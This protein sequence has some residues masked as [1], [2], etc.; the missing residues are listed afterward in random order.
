MAEYSV[1]IGGRA[2]E[3]LNKAGMVLCSL[4]HSQ[5]YHVYLYYDYPSLIRGGHNFSI[6][7]AAE[8]PIFAHRD[9]VDFLLAMNQETVDRHRTRLS[10]N[11]ILLYDDY[12]V[13]TQGGVGLPLERILKETGAPE[14]ARNTGIIAGFSCAAGIPWETLEGVL[15]R[16]IPRGIES[17]LAVARAVYGVGSTLRQIPALP[18]MGRFPILTGN[19]ATGIGL[20]AG[21]L[22]SFIAYP[23]TP[24]SNLLHF[25]AQHADRYGLKVVHPE[26]EIGVMLMA[27]GAAYGGE[28]VAVGT[29]GGGFCLMTE[30]LSL[31]GMAEIPVVIVLGQRPGP[32]TGL[33]TYSCQTEL[34][35]AISAG[36]GEFPRLVVAPANPAQAC[37]WSAAALRLA[38]KYQVPAFV[39][40]DKNVAEGAADVDPAGV[41]AAAPAVPVP[42]D[43]T[44]T[45]RRY[46]DTADGISPWLAPPAPGQT[47]KVN[48]YTHD[49]RG[50]S[51]EDPVLTARFQEK[52][53]R[54][55]AALAAEVATMSPVLS[56]GP[57]GARTVLFTWGSCTDVCIEVAGERG[58]RV[59]QPVV[60]WPFPAAAVRAAFAGADR[61]V[62]VEQNTTAQ[63][64]RLAAAEGIGVHDRILKYDGRPFSLEDLEARVRE[65]GA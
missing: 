35:F 59:V 54:K 61:V 43:G 12:T 16:E 3:G 10:E 46:A 47:V 49:E 9:R 52:L 20:L 18:G 65:V 24:T 31:A 53:Q 30:G 19:E 17:N 27:L 4:L 39:L 29:S 23:M 34:H 44:G 21:G 40:V 56:T 41:P 7:R 42:W 22:S 60:L 63:L 55:G 28:R 32:S 25:L 62:A 51:T 64:A 13:H 45:Y 15:R 36:Q 37:R 5:G 33:P 38:W 2:G 57:D 26:N 1:L 8:R 14:I 50:I 58:L 6:I 48:S 11:G